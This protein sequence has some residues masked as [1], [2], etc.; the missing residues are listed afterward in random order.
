MCWCYLWNLTKHG[1]ASTC[2]HMADVEAFFSLSA[3]TLPGYLWQIHVKNMDTMLFWSFNRQ[4]L[5]LLL[6]EMSVCA[7]HTLP[8]SWQ[9]QHW[10]YITSCI[11]NH[12]SS[13]RIAISQPSKPHFFL[14]LWLFTL[15]QKWSSFTE[16]PRSRVFK[17]TPQNPNNFEPPELRVPWF[18]PFPT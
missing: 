1:D 8:R 15:R 7:S 3:D 2:S 6:Y 5:P 9:G 12:Y 13:S 10:D 11:Q 16:I 14:P 18:E 17:F 4:T